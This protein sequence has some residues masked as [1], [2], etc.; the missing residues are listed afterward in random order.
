M[1]TET[2]QQHKTFP[3]WTL[4]VSE[5][6]IRAA[7]QNHT[8]TF[9]TGSVWAVSNTFC[10][11]ADRHIHMHLTA[12]LVGCAEPTACIFTIPYKQA[13]KTGW[14]LHLP[15]PPVQPFRATLDQTSKTNCSV[16]TQYFSQSSAPLSQLCSCLHY[17]NSQWDLRQI[18]VARRCEEMCWHLV[19][20][21]C[22]LKLVSGWSQHASCSSHQLRSHI[23]GLNSGSLSVR[24]LKTW[25]S[26]LRS[27]IWSVGN[28]FFLRLLLLLG[29]HRMGHER[30]INRK[31][32]TS[33]MIYCR[34]KESCRPRWV[35]LMWNVVQ[36]LWVKEAWSM[37]LFSVRV[38][39]GF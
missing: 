10:N 4:T 28:S 24:L 7:C 1:W 25:Q 33:I 39:V 17:K 6:C 21:S 27:P 30:I 14:C 8:H 9:L 22:W 13:V 34:R 38:F 26:P 16:K 36:K 19:K 35:S 37:F 23:N 29:L 3:V 31:N 12:L 15:V 2:R 11:F 5:S 18:F 32:K 20:R